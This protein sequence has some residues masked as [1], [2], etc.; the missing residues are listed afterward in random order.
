MTTNPG[1]M[2]GGFACPKTLSCAIICATIAFVA[3]L[4]FSPEKAPS[5]RL[6]IPVVIETNGTA[7]VMGETRQM[8]FWTP[9]VKTKDFLIKHD[10]KVSEREKWQILPTDDPVI[11]FGSVLHTNSSVF[12]YRRAEVWGQGRSDYKPGWWWTMTV[13][14]DFPASE[15]AHIYQ[16]Y[17]KSTQPVFVEVVDN[18]GS[19]DK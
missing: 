10:G 14:T 11:K 9:S 19:T 1:K 4:A 18:R 3:W 7:T 6:W 15:L 5:R 17:W 2:P 12:G 16:Q 13:S 8:E